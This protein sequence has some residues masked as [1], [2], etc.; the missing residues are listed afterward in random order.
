MFAFIQFLFFESM[1]ENVVNR[2]GKYL[3]WCNTDQL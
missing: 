3:Y 1:R 2:V